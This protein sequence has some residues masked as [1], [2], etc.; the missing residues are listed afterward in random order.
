MLNMHR[1]VG[2]LQLHAHRESLG[3]GRLFTRKQLLCGRSRSQRRN[4][5]PTAVRHR[6][7]DGA[8][9]VY[10]DEFGDEFEVTADRKRKLQDVQSGLA[11]LGLCPLLVHIWEKNAR[12]S[13]TGPPGYV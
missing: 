5:A 1:A 7:F 4:A 12:W 9:V 10:T 3:F 2:S 11:I 8:Q 6:R 13:K